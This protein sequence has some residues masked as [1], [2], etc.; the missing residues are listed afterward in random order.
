MAKK[1]QPPQAKR[2]NRPQAAN[3]VVAELKPHA[4]TTMGE[5]ATNAD[6]LVVASGGKSNLR[7]TAH[8]LPPRARNGRSVGRGQTHAADG[9]HG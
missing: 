8:Q 3:Q 5:L 6:Q 4:K 7:A 9:H 2:V 1:Q